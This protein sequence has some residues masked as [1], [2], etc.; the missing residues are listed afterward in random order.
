MMVGV[1]KKSSSTANERKKGEL[2]EQNQDALEYSSEEEQEDLATTISGLSKQKEQKV[3]KIDH[4]K[5]KYL[6]FRKDF[7]V[8]VPE[9]ARMT[10]EEVDEYRMELEGIKVKGKGCPKPIKTWAQCGVSKKEL[11]L[12]KRHGYEKPTPI[13]AQT[14]PAIMSGNWALVVVPRSYNRKLYKNSE[15]LKWLVENLSNY[16]F[17]NYILIKYYLCIS[18]VP[19]LNG[20]NVF[21]LHAIWF[22]RARHHWNC[23]NGQ[24]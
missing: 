9:M 13:Q 12:L 1:A 6:P 18:M 7:Y 4:N 21:F 17:I 2:L 22:E 23:Q 19:E 3:F 20:M 15:P 5:I 11:D 8:E 10:A 14:I 16:F 24:W